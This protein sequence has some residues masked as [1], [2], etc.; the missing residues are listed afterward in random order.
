MA[1][2]LRDD[3]L[4]ANLDPTLG[5]EQS[6]SPCFSVKS[7]CLQRSLGYG[8]RC[9]SHEPATTCRFSAN[10]CA[11][12]PELA[13]EILGKDKSDPTLSVQ[14]LGKRLGKATDEELTDIIKGLNEILGA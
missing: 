4:W 2:V 12:R 7:K 14:R 13:K 9:C 10:A 6:G 1:R 8:H 5:H 11:L 3:V